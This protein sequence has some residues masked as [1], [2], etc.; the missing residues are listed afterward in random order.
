M[1]YESV[2][3]VEPEEASDYESCSD[4]VVHA[5]N[6]IIADAINAGNNQITIT[7]NLRHGLP[8]ENINKIAGPIIEQWAFEA[9]SE[10]HQDARNKYRLIDVKAEERLNIS[11]IILQFQ[12]ES[13]GGEISTANVDVKATSHD[14]ENSGKSP[15]ITSFARIRNAYVHN[16]DFIFI[17]LSVK[18]KIDK[19]KSE[20]GK[21][22]VDKLEIVSYDTLDLKYVAENEIVYNPALGTGQ[23]QLRDIK[24]VTITR[25]TTTDFCRILDKKFIA[26]K[27]GFENW[28]DLATRHKW[29]K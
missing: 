2:E 7:T 18:H 4:Y 24:N 11:D 1:T 16:P 6:S 15:N 17:I 13:N 23:I 28:L 19:I 8:L 25:R 26:S 14:I 10:L 27:N 20:C 9:F 21:E 29:I 3:L 22:V 12:Q 5:I